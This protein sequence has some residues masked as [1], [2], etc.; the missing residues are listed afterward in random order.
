MLSRNGNGFALFFC[1]PRFYLIHIAGKNP[2]QDRPGDLMDSGTDSGR[3][4]HGRSK[5][6]RDEGNSQSIVLHADFQCNGV[7]LFF[8]Q[9]QFTR[10]EISDEKTAQIMNEYHENDEETHFQ[11]LG[12]IDGNNAA[13]DDQYAKS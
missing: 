3:N 9:S 4:G 11:N 6:D 10:N 1:I 12:T 5:E 7:L 2:S 8:A 13:D